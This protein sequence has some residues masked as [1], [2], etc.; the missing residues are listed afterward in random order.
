VPNIENINPLTTKGG[1][2]NAFTNARNTYG[3]PSVTKSVEG[4]AGLIALFIDTGAL[5]WAEQNSAT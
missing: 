5:S 2:S 4:V 1:G 3:D